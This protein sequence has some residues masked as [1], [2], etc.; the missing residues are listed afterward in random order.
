ME[1]LL[2]PPLNIQL[3]EASPAQSYDEVQSSLSSCLGNS[4][5]LPYVI[6]GSTIEIRN[7]LYKIREE[8]CFLR[9]RRGAKH[10]SKKHR[11]EHSK[12]RLKSKS[13]N[14]RV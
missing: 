11:K 3:L 12:H 7:H 14:K 4:A 10:N 13:S 8:V 2:S 9:D 5:V 6:S 1:S